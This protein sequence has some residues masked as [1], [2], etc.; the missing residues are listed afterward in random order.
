[1]KLE[2]SPNHWNIEEEEEGSQSTN[3][4][5]INRAHKHKNSSDKTWKVLNTLKI[6]IQKTALEHTK[7]VLISDDI[8]YHIY[9]EWN[10]KTETVVLNLN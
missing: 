9:N 3:N 4:I 8:F 10:H 5:Y 2:Q 6:H 7:N 1:M